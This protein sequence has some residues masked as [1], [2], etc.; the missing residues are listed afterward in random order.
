MESLLI[1]ILEKGPTHQG[2]KKIRRNAQKG[3]GQEKWKVEKVE[4]IK[5]L[6]TGVIREI[7]ARFFVIKPLVMISVF[8]GF[9]LRE[10]LISML[11]TSGWRS[12]SEMII[13]P[14]KIQK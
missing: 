1:G 11:W 13:I 12:V 2:D 4:E 3:R 10:I 9:I 5:Q 7:K 8:L 6:K 14:E